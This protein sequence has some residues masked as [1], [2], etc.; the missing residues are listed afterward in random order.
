[1]ELE[2]T[3]LND[4]RSNSPAP[5][6]PLAPSLEHQPDTTPSSSGTSLSPTPPCESQTMA[7]VKTACIW[8]SF[9]V[10]LGGLAVA[11]YYGFFAYQYQRWSAFNHFRG[12]C[13]NARVKFT[14]SY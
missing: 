9:A 10:S 3:E 2:M 7:A 6:L 8:L 13:R 14:Y 5:V 11:V 12:E 1:M 4:T